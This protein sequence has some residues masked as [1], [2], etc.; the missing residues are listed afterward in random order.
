MKKGLLSCICAITCLMAMAQWNA[1]PSESML[2][3]PDGKS[4]YANEMQIGEDGTTWLCVYHPQNGTVAT[5]I[6]AIDS[7]GVKPLGEE[8][9]LV[10]EERNMTYTVVNQLIMVD[11]DGN[12]IVV[13]HDLRNSPS[14]EQRLSYTIYKVSPEGEML[15]GDEG[16]A[17]DG[18]IAYEMSAAMKVIQLEDGSYVFAWMRLNGNL[19]A[20]EMQRVSNDGE[21][22]WNADDVRLMDNTSTYTYPNL[23]N[24]GDNQFILVYAK[25]SNQDLYARKID[26]DGTPVW[27]EDT[28]IYRGGFGS[29]PLW[30]ILDVQP[31]GDGGVIVSWNDDRY[32]TNIES[33]YLS[34]VKP[35]GEL[36]FTAGEEGQ[37]LGYAEWRSFNVTARYDS[38][39][40]SFIA[41]WRETDANQ[42]WYRLVAQRVS[43]QGELLWGEEGLELCPMDTQPI[44]YMDLQPGG[45]GEM[46]VFYMMNHSYGFGDVT[47]YAMLLNS[48][49][50]ESVWEEQ[51]FA[52]TENVS[53]KAS[54]EVTPMAQG[55]YWVAKWEDNGVL[56][57][58]NNVDRLYMQ[59]INRNMTLGNPEPGAVKA[60]RTEMSQFRAISTIVNDEAI[61]QVVNTKEQPVSISIY[62]MQGKLVTT[63]YNGIMP[64]GSH[65]VTWNASS[66]NLSKGIYLATLA[67]QGGTATVKIIIN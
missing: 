22:L 45:E 19:F 35:N 49:T 46:G 17:V 47:C 34:Y 30:T 51:P 37:K 12:A 41:L 5:T 4:Y 16:I 55:D 66:C 9:L 8:G 58:D 23:V 2:A 42:N 24:D 53:E 32:Y 14:E 21:L 29:I 13:V 57:S 48:E 50:G 65:Y 31:S 33:A 10:S 7:T 18:A 54:L 27:P 6:Q 40:N 20:I 15:W 43:L 59:R 44:A 63:A 11:K 38:K 28:R 62:D 39:T 64:Q 56:G 26:F 36:G 67:S 61:F 3:W 60:T 1:N 52:F 25:G